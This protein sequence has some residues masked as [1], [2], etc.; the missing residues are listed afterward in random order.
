MQAIG[1]ELLTIAAAW[2]FVL[3]EWA[4]RKYSSTTGEETESYWYLSAERTGTAENGLRQFLLPADRLKNEAALGEGR[5]YAGNRLT[6]DLYIDAAGPRIRLYINVQKD[7]VY[8][9]VLK[10]TVSIDNHRCEAD[11]GQR[12]RLREYTVMR[13][14]DAQLQLRRKKVSERWLG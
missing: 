6:D 2:I 10:G 1:W 9:S 8:L 14:A 3:T 11:P 4:A 13:V 5:Y 12:I 7:V